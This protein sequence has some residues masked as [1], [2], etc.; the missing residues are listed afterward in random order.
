MVQGTLRL[1]LQGFQDGKSTSNSVE[2]AGQ[3]NGIAVKFKYYQRLDGAF[4]VPAGMQAH[5]LLVEL[6]EAGS[7]RGK[8]TQLVKLPE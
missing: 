5:S 7:K 2:P 6:T 3:R 1:V 8:L 4:S